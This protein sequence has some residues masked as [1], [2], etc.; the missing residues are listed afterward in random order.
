MSTDFSCIQRKQ[1]TSE[2][3][4]CKQNLA[5]M[6]TDIDYYTGDSIYSSSQAA[7][8]RIYGVTEEGFSVM[9]HVHCFEPYF[10]TDAPNSVNHAT[11]EDV[12][13]KINSFTQCRDM[14]EK[15]E[16]VHK[17]SIMNFSEEGPRNFFKI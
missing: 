4:T 9:V 5:F 1:I 6:L 11:A 12:K 16:I 10:W 13:T 15:I 17:E 3:C 8:I 14:V 7:I 2:Y